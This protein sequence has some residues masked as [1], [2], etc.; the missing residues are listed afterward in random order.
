[1]PSR[2]HLTLFARRG[3][4]LAIPLARQGLVD[5]GATLALTTGLVFIAT[6]FFNLGRN[7]SPLPEPRKKHQLVVSGIYGK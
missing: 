4:G 5:F 1:L 7:I 6:A 3:P 2:P